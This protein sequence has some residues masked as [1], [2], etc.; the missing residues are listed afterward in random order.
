[1]PATTEVAKLI[2]FARDRGVMLSSDGPANNVFKIKPPLVL[3]RSD[4]DTFPELVQDGL[5]AV[6]R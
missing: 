5:A 6:A 1:M 2:E 4:V 3:Q